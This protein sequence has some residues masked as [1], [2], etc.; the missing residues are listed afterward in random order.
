MQIWIAAPPCL[1]ASLGKS[2]KATHSHYHRDGFHFNTTQHNYRTSP[3][4]T[5]LPRLF[6]EIKE[7]ACHLFFSFLGNKHVHYN[8]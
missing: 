8:N 4:P 2:K 5:T 6:S 3:P 1:A 7:A